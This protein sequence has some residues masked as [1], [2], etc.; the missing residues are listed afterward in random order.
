MYTSKK[1][2]SKKLDTA[3]GNKLSLVL[4]LFGG[5]CILLSV[6]IFFLTFSSVIKEEI[7][8]AFLKPEKD[9]EVVIEQKPL[10]ESTSEEKDTTPKTIITPVDPYFSIVIPKIGA[11]SKVIENVDPNN[12]QEYQ[13]Q[14]SK[15]VAHAKGTAIPGSPG[16][17]FLFAHS[18][19][20]FYQANQY[21]AVFYLL[22]KLE[23]GDTIYTV[24]YKQK[25]TYKITDIKVV[26]PSEVKYLKNISEK[27]ILTLMTCT[28][29]GTTISRLI[30]TAELVE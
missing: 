6:I 5:G 14:L 16:N 11:N 12:E 27:P 15:G 3:T 7:K 30:V 20:N 2:E 25:Y 17:S 29:A 18:A 21:N 10:K 22:N 26:D 23:K 9:T 4:M 19:G 8:Y 24:Y 28:P 1:I 13:W